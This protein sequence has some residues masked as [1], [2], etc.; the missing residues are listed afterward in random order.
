M[1][2][3]KWR[4]RLFLLVFL[5]LI[6]VIVLKPNEERE[7]HTTDIT[8]SGT[9]GN[10][11]DDGVDDMP[12]TTV[13]SNP[14]EGEE[15]QDEETIVSRMIDRV[16]SGEIELSEE[17]SIRQALE[18]AEHE[19]KISLTQ[20]NKDKVVS[21][22]KTLGTVGVETEDFIDQAKEKYQT[23]STGFVEEA[24]EAINEAV[25]GAVAGA[26]RN[27]FD[28]IRQAAGDFFKNLIP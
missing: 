27:F 2:K 1:R 4:R 25:E 21:F 15:E 3:H 28:N 17:D 14:E 11:G 10:R 9:P 16:A 18:E 6:G 19:L 26:A 5:V 22:L 24:N 12:E 20:D 13:S 23:Y 8:A 7:D